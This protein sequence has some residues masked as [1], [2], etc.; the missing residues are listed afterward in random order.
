MRTLGASMFGLR[1]GSQYARRYVAL[2]QDQTF[3][4][5][6]VASVTG[7]AFTVQAGRRYSF[8]FDMIARTTDATKGL[9]ATVTTPTFTRFSAICRC[10]AG[11]SGG[12]GEHQIEI[13]ASGTDAVFA[14][15]TGADTD[16]IASI[17]GLILP[18]ANGTIQVK[19]GIEATAAT[20]TIGQPSAGYID[21]MGT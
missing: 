4:S 7:L 19:V 20:I 11:A 2:R 14:N 13:T 8:R 5:A 10:M 15:F 6:T 3:N 16:Y 9:R 21:D 1:L 12:G 17:H 18:T